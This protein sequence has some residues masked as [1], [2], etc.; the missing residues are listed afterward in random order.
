[1]AAFT[2]FC[3]VYNHNTFFPQWYICRSKYSFS[4]TLLEIIKSVIHC[5]RK[6]NLERD[7]V[8]YYPEN[9]NHRPLSG[10]YRRIW[11]HLLSAVTASVTGGT[12][13]FTNFFFFTFSMHGSCP[14]T[15]MHTVCR[16]NSHYLLLCHDSGPWT[17]TLVL[18]CPSLPLYEILEYVSFAAK[19]IVGQ[20]SRT[21]S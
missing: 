1:M 15:L 18:L 3:V 8:T 4:P 16:H 14:Y 9:E 7:T 20:N 17:L 21:S 11:T 2:N 12:F 6:P 10:S 5:K 13:R 19:R